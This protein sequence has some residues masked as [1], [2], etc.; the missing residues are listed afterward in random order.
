[1][2]HVDV[3]NQ[4]VPKKR[5]VGDVGDIYLY[6]PSTDY[7]KTKQKKTYASNYRQ[8]IYSNPKK[9][10]ELKARDRKRKMEAKLRKLKLKS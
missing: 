2:L 1:M 4:K 10:E 7:F 6:L 3:R 8:R 9:H 5:I